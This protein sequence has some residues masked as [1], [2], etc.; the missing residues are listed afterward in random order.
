M[1]FFNVTLISW[2][3][4]I[5]TVFGVVSIWLATKEKIINYLFGIVSVFLFSIIF[6]YTKLY[7]NL[8]LQF[9]FIIANFYGMYSWNKN[10]KK[11]KIRRLSIIQIFI[12]AFISIFS[13][14]FCTIY[15]ND[16]FSF[17]IKI[18]I[19]FMYFFNIKISNFNTNPDPFP[20]FDSTI[21][22]LSIIAM[23]LLVKKYIENWFLWI[24]VNIMSII[25][26]F[27]K[28]IYIMSIQYIILTLI[29]LKG[30]YSWYLYYKNNH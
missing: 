4:F 27:F 28:K 1:D 22:V 24:I 8:F 20:F 3:E 18:F 6:F 25:L 21:A 11:I 9:F 16:I 14:L 23:I 10:R 5:G 15:V 29:C 13:I 2:I 7:A 26:L 30:F 19:K 17:F 12:Y